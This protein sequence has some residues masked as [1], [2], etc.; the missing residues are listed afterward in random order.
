MLGPQPVCEQVLKKQSPLF[1][2]CLQM[3]EAIPE[4]PKLFCR[5]R[6]KLHVSHDDQ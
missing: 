3:P 5:L 1:P 4:K 6:L 2:K